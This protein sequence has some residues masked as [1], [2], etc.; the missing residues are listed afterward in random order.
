MNLTV[1]VINTGSELLLGA[2]L[3]THGAWLGSRLLELGLRVGRQTTVPD[4]GAIGFALAESAARADVVL[5]TGGLG[6]T[7]DDLTR[8]A[9]AE[10]FSCPLEEDERALRVLTAYFDRRALPMAESNLKQALVPRGAEVLD[11]PHGTAPGLY[12]PAGPGRPHLFLMPGP[13]S[14]LYPMF[15]GEVIP[16]LRELCR[17]SGQASPVC[18]TLKTS[19][20]GESL[21]HERVDALLTSLDGLEV[22]YCARPGEVDV[23]LIGGSEVVEEG[24]EIVRRELAP[25]LVN[26]D[27]SSLEESLVA[28]LAEHGKKIATAESCTGGMIASRLTDVA[29]ASA[30]FEFGWVTYANEAKTAELGVS[31][32]LLDQWGAVSEPVARAMAEG[33][34]RASGADMAVAVTGIAGPGGGSEEKPVGTVWVAWACKGGETRAECFFYP[35]RRDVFRRRVVQE[36]LTGAFFLMRERLTGKGGVS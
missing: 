35:S 1:E 34:L 3:N 22:G 10:L 13:P 6:P 28:L 14:E 32:A 9:V 23:R 5:V 4:G 8:E 16:R 26:E 17:R 25:W 12:L 33:A 29:G 27:G 21:L 2:V 36:A 18:L 7:S 19:G 31:G 24:R 20:I 11:N 30:V 15:E